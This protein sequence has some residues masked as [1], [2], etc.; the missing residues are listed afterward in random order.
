MY[1][2]RWEDD[3]AFGLGIGQTDIVKRPTAKAEKISAAEFAHGKRALD[4]RLEGVVAELVIFTFKKAATKLFDDFEGHGF[5]S[6]FT[7]CGGEVF[8]MPGPY[9]KSEV[10]DRS[11]S[12]LR[13][14]VKRHARVT[15]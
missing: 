9:E 11:L 13:A 6:G 1:D 15:L 12:E 4:K 5:I 8:V 2:G 3:V 14:W 10:A 7:L